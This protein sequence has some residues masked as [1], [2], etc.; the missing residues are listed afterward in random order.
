MDWLRKRYELKLLAWRKPAAARKKQLDCFWYY[1]KRYELRTGRA[2]E[3]MLKTTTPAWEEN[4]EER[5]RLDEYMQQC[6]ACQVGHWSKK[7]RRRRR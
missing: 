4:A 1:R 7:V 5:R 3:S 6:L 2:W